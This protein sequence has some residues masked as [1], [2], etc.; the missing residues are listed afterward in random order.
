MIFGAL[1]IGSN[2]A[3]FQIARVIEY[4]GDLTFKKVEYIRYPLRL[5]EDVFHNGKISEDRI[6]KIIKL[7]EICKEMMS[8]YDVQVYSAY[9]TSAMREAKNSA[10]II[11][12]VISTTGINLEVIDGNK[13]AD[14]INKVIKQNIDERSYIH[15]DVGGGST[16]LNIY[17][18]GEIKFTESFKIGTIRNLQQNS[19]SED[20]K[21]MKTWVKDI[22]KKYNIDYA[23]GTGGNIKKL[24]EISQKKEG[25]PISRSNIKSIREYLSRFS[26]E[27]RINLLQLNADRADVI[28]PAS[29]IYESIMK[30][31]GTKKMFVPSV[32][33]K[34]GMFY[35]LYEQIKG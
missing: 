2:A 5:G 27:E 18:K 6:N 16:E 31:S 32:G 7:C 33:L 8:L 29:D 10:N 23:I 17:N 1:D 30:W 20:W 19:K 3:R 34:D 4:K 24:H 22:C 9:A 26:I 11:K 28:I 35:E 25:K 15:I 14:L 12:K 13:E 21:L